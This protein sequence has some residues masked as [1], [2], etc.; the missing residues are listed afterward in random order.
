MALALL[1]LTTSLI[2]K[3]FGPMGQTFEIKEEDLR[4]WM[5]KRLNQ[6]GSQELPLKR[7]SEQARHPAP[8]SWLHE[9]KEPRTSYYDPTYTVS[10]TIRTP[11][12]HLL[13]KKGT[14]VNPLADH[15]LSSGLLFIDGENPS[16]LAW[17]R[18][19]TGEFKWVLV[20]GSPFDLEKKEQR[21]VYFDMNGWIAK[22]LGIASVPVRIIQDGLRLKIEEIPIREEGSEV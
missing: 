9:A 4:Q 10:E 3:D 18:K 2:G 15:A 22:K 8:V 11:N 13:A 14:V 7:L 5:Q 21:P 20:R 12:G 19:Q 1:S 16:H 17:A 6:K